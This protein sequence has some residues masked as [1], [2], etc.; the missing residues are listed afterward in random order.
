MCA[1]AQPVNSEKGRTCATF[2]IFSLGIP[3]DSAA[4]SRNDSYAYCAWLVK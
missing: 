2:C 3:R 4:L 1:G